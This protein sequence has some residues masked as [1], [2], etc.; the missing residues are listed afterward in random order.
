MMKRHEQSGFSLI[1][2]IFLLVV[3]ASL[4]AFVVV[5]SGVSQQTPV[6]AYNGAR[7]YQAAHAGLEWGVERAINGGGACN[8]NFLVDGFAVTVACPAPTAHSDGP[9]TI[10]IFVVNAVAV[11]GTP[12][13]LDYSRR[14]L[15][16]VVSPSGPL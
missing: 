12:G 9:S 1:T 8:G 11:R 10:N 15:S 16:A 13:Q 7:A 3:L 2:A 14:A 5:L 6:L 4:A